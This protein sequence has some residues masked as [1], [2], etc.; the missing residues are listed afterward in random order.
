MLFPVCSVHMSPSF[1]SCLFICCLPVFFHG[2]PA[3]FLY[4]NIFP[5]AIFPMA[6]LHCQNCCFCFFIPV[7]FPDFLPLSNP[8]RLSRV[9]LSLPIPF[10]HVHSLSISVAFRLLFLQFT[11][12]IFLIFFHCSKFSFLSVMLLFHIA[13][14]FLTFFFYAFTL[15]TI[16]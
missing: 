10:H 7:A 12:F 5:L 13:P 15:F 2:F 9:F 4:L 8:H 1:Y 3:D 16:G 6:F 11:S 14:L